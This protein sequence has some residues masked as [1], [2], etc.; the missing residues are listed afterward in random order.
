VQESAPGLVLD[1]VVGSKEALQATQVQHLNSGS[2]NGKGDGQNQS[3]QEPKNNEVNLA[4]SRLEEFRPSKV[5]PPRP[6]KKLVKYQVIGRNNVAVPT[7]LY[8]VS[9]LPASVP[10]SLYTSTGTGI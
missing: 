6:R 4:K 9:Y 3:K 8:K 5:R 1:A 10:V 2:E 7:H